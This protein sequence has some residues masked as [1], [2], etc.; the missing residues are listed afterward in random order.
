[1]DSD[2]YYMQLA[3]KEAIKQAER[4]G[5]GKSDQRPNPL[6]GCV[7]VM[8]DGQV[9]AGYRGEKNPSDHAEFT[10]LEKKLKGVSVRGASVFT[11]L[12]P[13]TH[14]GPSKIPCADRLV[15]AGVARVVIG[16]MDPDDRGRG[17][18]KLVEAG[19]DVQLFDEDLALQIRELNIYFIESR[20]ISSLSRPWFSD[21]EKICN[22][23]V[24]VVADLCSAPRMNPLGPY[25]FPDE[26]SSE[27]YIKRAENERS[28]GGWLERI[29]DFQGL[30]RYGAL[31]DFYEYDYIH[32][33][34]LRNAGHKPKAV[35]AGAVL[36]CPEEASLY[37]HRRSQAVATE[38]GKFHAFVGGY[39]VDYQNIADDTLLNACLRE[40]HEESSAQP[41]LEDA[42][43]VIVEDIEVG[44]ID[45][46]FM[47]GVIYKS[48]AQRLKGSREGKVVSLPF[49]KLVYEFTENREAW[50]STGVAH[51]LIW[52]KLGAP[53]AP[54]WF[55]RD[56][57]GLF[58]QIAN[59]SRR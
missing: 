42:R 37:V 40:L 24:R 11:T 35:Y 51:H 44:W 4:Y 14:R 58:E 7:V 50:V 3:L 43:V 1:M 52:L 46:M 12:E 33:M 54:V 30:R 56:A 38:P 36:V 6:V 59:W 13:C 19:I 18:H 57:P 53:G 16:Y 47:A 31:L 34:T 32:W 2:R 5:S 27:Y 8:T 45:V 22:N 10:V 29:A 23:R 17:Y 26:L 9:E 39:I 21:V 55:Q 20:K 25:P 15:E 49:K 28:H 48:N 41:Q